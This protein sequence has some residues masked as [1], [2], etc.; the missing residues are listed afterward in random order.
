[1]IHLGKNAA[2]YIWPQYLLRWLL[3]FHFQFW[4]RVIHDV[5]GCDSWNRGDKRSRI[6][7]RSASWIPDVRHVLTCQQSS[8]ECGAHALN[9]PFP[10]CHMW[11][12]RLQAQ[13]QDVFGSAAFR[14]GH[15]CVHT[16]ELV[17]GAPGKWQRLYLVFNVAPLISVSTQLLNIHDKNSFSNDATTTFNSTFLEADVHCLLLFCFI[18]YFFLNLFGF[19]YCY[20]THDN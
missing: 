12:H 16:A 10:N 9:K 4:P 11:L 2:F 18:Y 8:A 7:P 1:M 20:Y 19:F 15:H 3:L 14:S 13:G 6:A 17:H 5:F